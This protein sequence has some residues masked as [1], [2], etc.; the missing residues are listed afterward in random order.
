MTGRTGQQPHRQS[1]TRTREGQHSV[2]QRT[3]R[4]AAAPDNLTDEGHEGTRKA[5]TACTE[6]H[7]A[8]PDN[9]LAD[10]RHKD[11]RKAGTA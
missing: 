3:E 5:G 11:T 6:W 8:A 7:P 4:P 9:N 2:T 10:E 1:A